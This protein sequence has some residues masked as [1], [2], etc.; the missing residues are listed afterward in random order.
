MSPDYIEVAKNYRCESCEHH[1]PLD[2]THKVALPEKFS[3]NHEIGID[4]LEVKDNNGERYTFL[5][6]ACQ[7]ATFQRVTF[8]KQGGGTPYSRAR[9]AALQQHLRARA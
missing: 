3:C 1:K 2:Q 5:N 9:H 8:V 4:G 6:R 7:G